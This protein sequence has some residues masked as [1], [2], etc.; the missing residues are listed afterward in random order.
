MKMLEAHY[1]QITKGIH[2]NV[3]KDL[4]VM[5]VTP[6]CKW[7]LAD[8]EQDYW[9]Y[10]DDFPCI[11]PPSPLTWLEYEAPDR[12]QSSEN[13]VLNTSLRRAGMCAITYEVEP[14]MRRMALAD[15]LLLRY[16]QALDPQSREGIDWQGDRAYRLRWMMKAAERQI[17]PRWITIWNIIA[18][19]ITSREILSM[20]FYG[21]YLDEQGRCIKGLNSVISPI[22]EAVFKATGEVID[23]FVDALPFMF[24]LSLSHCKNVTSKDIVVAPAVAKKRAQKGLPSLTYRILDIGPMRHS[25]RH[26]ADRPSQSETRNALHFV[27]GHMKTFSAD[28]PLFGRHVGTYW[29]HLQA[30]G[31]EAVGVAE[32]EYRVSGPAGAT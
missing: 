9:D 8:A 20:G 31:S 28:K 30:R 21:M 25:S 17:Y 11:V 3:L 7:F 2:A 23:P 32:K 24:A 27:R 16:M 26:A 19:P 15:D 4:L 1:Q 22:P 5:D 18:E 29:W 12:L 6:A 14:E 13:L 10:T